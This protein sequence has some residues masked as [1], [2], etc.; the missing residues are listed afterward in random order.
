[1]TKDQRIFYAIGSSLFQQ[2][3]VSLIQ[4]RNATQATLDRAVKENDSDEDQ[5]MLREALKHIQS[6]LKN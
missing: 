6:M 4:M 2:G 5:K 3:T 1:M